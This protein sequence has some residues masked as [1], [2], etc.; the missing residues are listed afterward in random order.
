MRRAIALAL[1]L[2]AAGCGSHASKQ[3][4][5]SRAATST[6]RASSV[7]VTITAPTHRPCVNAPWPVTVRVTNS[8]GQ[9]IPATLT[10]RI[11]FSGT[12]VG[13]VDNGRV[14]HVVGTWKEKKGQEIT[15]PRASR[16]QPL[17]FEAIVQAQ[18]M[19]V[20]RTWAIRAR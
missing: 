1:V 7:R 9:P 8:A 16:G 5:T 20:K 2:F 13:K 3:G 17:Q 6:S 12:P 4:A 19:T 18:H 14:Y 15:W 10:M 11:L